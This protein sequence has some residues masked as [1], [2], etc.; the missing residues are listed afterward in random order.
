M[1][2][3]V[4][5]VAAGVAS[6]SSLGL[7]GGASSRALTELTFV[8]AHGDCS[9][10]RTM[11]PDGTGVR[12]I[13]PCAFGVQSPDWSPDGRLLVFVDSKDGGPG[14]YV[15]RADGGDRRRI[16][17]G[18]PGAGD[19]AW[20]PDGRMIAYVSGR[21]LLVAN[22]DGTARTSVAR[23]ALEIYGPQ[24]SPDGRRIV[25]SAG[26]FLENDLDLYVVTVATK[27]VARLTR[28]TGSAID[29]AW[30]PD[31]AT[32]AFVHLPPNDMLGAVQVV[33]S[34]GSGRRTLLRDPLYRTPAWSPE[35]TRIAVVRGGEPISAA[36]IYTVSRNGDDLR[37]VTRNRIDDTEPDW[38]PP[39]NP[40]ERG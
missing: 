9:Q 39:S 14:L 10:I 1:R 26:G 18:D 15:V 31:G 36:E 24:W 25:Y 21:R 17:S 8:Q 28:S 40:R 34:D 20:S 12:R 2:L 3:L 16:V 22:A 19:P 33:R 13:V 23:A 11:R 5:V 32:I 4:A 38:R 6:T 27:R 37:R 30:S 7:A 35:G 29:P